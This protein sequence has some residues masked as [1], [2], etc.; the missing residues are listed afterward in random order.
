[1]SDPLDHYIYFDSKDDEITH[2]KGVSMNHDYI[3]F[4]NSNQAWKLSLKTKQIS[5]LKIYISENDDQTFIKKLRTT[6]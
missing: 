4:W 6:S 3:F 5:L 2:M 1:M